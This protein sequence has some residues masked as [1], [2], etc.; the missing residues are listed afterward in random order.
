MLKSFALEV[1]NRRAIEEAAHFLR[2]EDHIA[3]HRVALLFSLYAGEANLS[4]EKVM[5]LICRNMEY[6]VFMENKK[7]KEVIKILGSDKGVAFFETIVGGV[8]FPGLD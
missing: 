6:V 8:E 5:E 1:E 2:A 7:V 4:F 3:L